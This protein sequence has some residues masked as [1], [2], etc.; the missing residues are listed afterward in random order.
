MHLDHKM[1]KQ[2]SP[3]DV[4]EE[5]K[6]KIKIIQNKLGIIEKLAALLG[7][8][9]YSA[10][11]GSTTCGC[12]PGHRGNPGPPGIHGIKGER[13]DIGD[14]GP[15]GVE[16]VHGP[17]GPRGPLGDRGAPGEDAPYWSYLPGYPGP[18]G[19]PGRCRCPNNNWPF[20]PS[21]SGSS[22]NN[23]NN[24]YDFQQAYPY[25]PGSYYVSDNRGQ[26]SYLE[27]QIRN[28]CCSRGPHQPAQQQPVPQRQHHHRRPH[29]RKP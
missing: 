28:N 19:P 21:S 22:S 13:G 10:N 4:L 9:I 23:N 29:Q 2:C 14:T 15:P 16:G 18:P 1:S 8:L 26:L 25:K 6:G 12:S 24:N 20:R 7:V 3:Q 17:E 11:A 27:I 5:V